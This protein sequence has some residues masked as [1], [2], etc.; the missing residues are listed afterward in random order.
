MAVYVHIHVRSVTGKSFGILYSVCLLK[1][2]NRLTIY[3]FQCISFSFSF[4][5]EWTAVTVYHTRIGNLNMTFWQVKIYAS[6]N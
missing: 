3:F 2:N 6:N 4:V 1:R 5:V